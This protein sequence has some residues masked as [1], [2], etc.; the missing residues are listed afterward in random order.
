MC[1]GNNMSVASRSVLPTSVFAFAVSVLVWLSATN[2][3]AKPL[4]PGLTPYG[5]EQSANES[6]SIPAWDGGLTPENTKPV[7]DKLEDHYAAEK[8]LYVITSANQAEHADHLSDGQKALLKA[9][10]ES[11]NL[12]VYPSHRTAAAT[13]WVYDNIASN[14]QT[15]K[16]VN[17]GNGF[18]DAF[19]GVPFPVPKN[20]A[21]EYDARKILWNHLTRWRGLFIKAVTSE[22]PVHAN[23]KYSIVSADQSVYF[24]YYDPAENFKTIDNQMSQFMASIT[25]PSRLAGGALLVHETIDRIKEDRSAWI[26]NAGTRRVRR[27][28]SVGY[29][30]P[31]PSADNLLT[32]DDVDMFNGALDRYDWR[33][34]GKQEM[35]IPYNNFKLSNQTGD[36]DQLLKKGH[37]NPDLTR[38]EMHRVW[39]I[40]GSVKK[41]TRHLYSKRRF[42][43]DEDSW[44]IVQADQYDARGNLWRVHVSYLVNYYHVPVT[45]SA[46]SVNHDLE[47]KRYYASFLDNSNGLA[48][49][50]LNAPPKKGEFSPQALRRGGTR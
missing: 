30:N 1:A 11:Y 47:S 3:Y 20:E 45:W 25:K 27:A 17:D 12:P 10:P 15:A 24:L 8:P 9:Y 14:H 50:F 42:Y 37:V 5:A 13:P 46:L 41:G 16:L 44:S 40:E 31:V 19:G 22:A 21:G 33:F 34:V 36:Y 39:V 49:E 32:A 26:Y 7:K 48:I 35:L 43:L 28:P 23:G 4:A 29:D 2:G 6:G 38:Y 18:T